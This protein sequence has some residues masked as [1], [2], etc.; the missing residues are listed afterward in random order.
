VHEAWIYTAATLLALWGA[1][2]LV[3]TPRVI[4]SLHPSTVDDRRVI[5]MEW[6]NE[7]LTLVFLAGIAIT[8]TLLGDS[9]VTRSVLWGTVIML[10]VMSAASLA[11][12][13]RVKFI[14]YR[15]CPVIFTG[16]S[17]LIVAG[18]L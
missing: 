11:T 15:L 5:T 7:G 9:N 12:G 14:A 3:N 8:V 17:L 16:S 6:I 4:P 18:L 2:H 1:A 10:N 13:F